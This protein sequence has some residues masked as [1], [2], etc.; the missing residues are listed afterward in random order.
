M[1]PY[2]TDFNALANR[3]GLEETFHL[4]MVYTACLKYL[5][6]Q[7]FHYVVAL[8][9]KQFSFHRQFKLLANWK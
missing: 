4:I 9:A 2:H 5:L 7:N 3:T 8:P 1:P 6:D